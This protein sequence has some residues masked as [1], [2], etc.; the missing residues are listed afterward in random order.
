MSRSSSSREAEKAKCKERIRSATKRR[1]SSQW[2]D[3][4][5][6]RQV[7]DIVQE[8]DSVEA[9]IQ[10]GTLDYITKEC[11]LGSVHPATSC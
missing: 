10:R 3:R 2:D 8:A 1:N 5:L 7:M 9:Q 4:E 6:A 11:P